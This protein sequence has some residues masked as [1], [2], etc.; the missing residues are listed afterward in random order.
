GSAIW[1]L[2]LLNHYASVSRL[3]TAAQTLAQNQID[4]IL[5]KGPYDPTASRYPSPNILGTTGTYNYYTDPVAGTINVVSA[6]ATPS[7][8]GSPAVTIYKDPMNTN[9]ATNKIVTGTIFTSVKDSG[10]SVPIPVA[11]GTPSPKSLSLRQATVTVSYRYRNRNYSVVMDTMR[12]AD[13]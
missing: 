3:Y 1:G 7:P 10:A 12:T 13:Q 6:T 4:L 5:T 2:N 8:T 9:A 11:S